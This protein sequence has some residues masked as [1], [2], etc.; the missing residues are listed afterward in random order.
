ME[1]SY[2]ILILHTPLP[3]YILLSCIL[4]RYFKPSRPILC[5]QFFFWDGVSL[6]L[7][8]LECNGAISAHRNLHLLDSGNSSASASWV[9]GITGTRHRA[10]LIFVF[11]VEMGFTMLTR[12]VSISWPR[13]PS[14]S[15]SQNAGITGLSHRT[16]PYMQN[17]KLIQPPVWGLVTP[18]WHSVLM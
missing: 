2:N 15:A 17:F 8:S 16:W 14:A 12:M 4:F 5:I 18:L 3:I 11:L 6:S 9:A 10:Q 7:P 1:W 13:D